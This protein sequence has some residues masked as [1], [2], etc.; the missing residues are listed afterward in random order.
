MSTNLPP[1]TP[2]EFKILEL[3]Q[4]L[5]SL[6]LEFD[7]WRNSSRADKLLE[8]HHSQIRRITNQVEGYQSVIQEQL[9]LLTSDADEVFSKSR[10]L[11]KQILELHRIWEF[12][13]NKFVLRNVPWFNAYLIAADEFA[14]VCYEAAQT[15]VPASNIS[16]RQHLKEPPLVFFNGGSSPFSMPRKLAYRAEDIPRE[17]LKTE[18]FF[19]LISDLPVPLIGI[20]WFQIQY[21]PDAVVIGHEVGH[22]VRDDFG[23]VS[24]TE[25]L[26]ANGM[27]KAPV[28]PERQAAWSAWL[29]EIFAD[30]YGTLATGPAF[31]RSLMNSLA[32]DSN[33]ITSEKRTSA[34]WGTYPPGYLRVLVNIEVLVKLGFQS[35]AE[36]LKTAWQ[37]VFT[38]QHAMSDFEEDIDNILESLLAGPYPEFGN[39]PLTDVLVFSQPNNARTKKAAESLLSGGKLLNLD[40]RELYAAANLAF[41]REPTTYLDRDIQRLVVDKILELRKGG[42]R[43]VKGQLTDLQQQKDLASGRALFEKIEQLLSSQ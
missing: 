20:P 6:A 40:V 41:A 31:V 42:I 16:Q 39:I 38:S 35:E 28:H 18:K 1:Q 34:N 17:G 30:L 11:E 13:R 36:E 26:L 15:R 37:G 29:D 27:S 33:T 32:K 25:S 23:L 7:M 14:W 2:A 21:L 12:F 10:D 5:K 9:D 4:K 22:I 19:E 8:K 24:R 43:K 3:K